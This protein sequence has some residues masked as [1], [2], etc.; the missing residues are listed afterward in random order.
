[1]NHYNALIRIIMQ[2]GDRHEVYGEIRYHWD[3][4]TVCISEFVG[5]YIYSIP[6]CGW[7]KSEFLN[8]ITKV[9]K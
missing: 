5:L 9:H 3:N 1:M 7:N 6:I 8:E 4:Y 2:Y